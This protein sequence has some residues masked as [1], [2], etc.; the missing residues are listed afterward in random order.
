MLKKDWN[1]GS[2]AEE[3]NS[4]HSYIENIDRCSYRRIFDKSLFSAD[5]EEKAVCK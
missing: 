2:L 4:P 5:I 1:N 3:N